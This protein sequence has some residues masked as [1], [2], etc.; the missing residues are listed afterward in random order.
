MSLTTR[1]KRLNVDSEEDVE[2]DTIREGSWTAYTVPQLRMGLRRMKRDIPNADEM[3]WDS[4]PHEDDSNLVADV[5]D[6]WTSWKENT[7]FQTIH[8]LKI[9]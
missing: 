5:Q 8:R 6:C 2:W 3:P 4:K 9:K 7:L 1:L